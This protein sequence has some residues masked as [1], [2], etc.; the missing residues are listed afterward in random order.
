MGQKKDADE[1]ILKIQ[2]NYKSD[3]LLEFSVALIY[4]GM[5]EKDNS[6]IWLNRSQEKYGFVYRD[7][8]I[9][10]DVRM[11]ELKKDRRFENLIYT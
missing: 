2:R 6:F 5:D 9:G 1:L 7:K 11:K 3:P 4:A 10:G 8:T